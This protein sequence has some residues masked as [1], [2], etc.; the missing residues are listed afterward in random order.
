M[1]IYLM[2]HSETDWNRQHRIQGRS[3]LH[4]NMNGMKIAALSGDGMAEIPIDACF[5]SP[6]M[7][8]QETAAI[9][10]ARNP[11][12]VK[13]GGRI[14]LDDRLMEI[15]FG[16]WEGKDSIFGPDVSDEEREKFNLFFR[17]LD[18]GYVP[19]GAEPLRSVVD[20]GDAFLDEIAGREDLKDKT[21]LV[22]THGC[23]FRCMLYRFAKDRESYFRKPQILFNCATAQIDVDEEGR[24]ELSGVGRIFY[25]EALAEDFYSKKGTGQEKTK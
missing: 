14:R 10:L 11:H 23:T 22:L 5:S 24:M 19:E 8:A 21:V 13:E 15:C 20:R 12:Y 4:L 25:D 9:V 16:E 18:G 3:D 7:R 2:R 6:L 1:R 17:S